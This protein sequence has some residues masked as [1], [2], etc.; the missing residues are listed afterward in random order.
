[1]HVFTNIGLKYKLLVAV[2]HTIFLNVPLCDPRRN[3]EV[4]RCDSKPYYS[5][6]RDIGGHLIWRFGSGLEILA[7]FKFLRL[8]S[9]V[10]F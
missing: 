4:Q 2:L 5:I 3:N 10:S 8:S 1:M 7:G 9:I 6:D